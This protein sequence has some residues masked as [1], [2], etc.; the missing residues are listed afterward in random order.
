MYKEKENPSQGVSPLIQQLMKI[1]QLVIWEPNDK[2]IKLITKL[3]R[4]LQ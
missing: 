4:S 1:G 3:P 2:D